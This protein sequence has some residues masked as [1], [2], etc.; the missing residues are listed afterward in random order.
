MS[1]VQGNNTGE[2]ADMYGLP[3]AQVHVAL[4]YYFE[5]L[6]EIREEIRSGERIVEQVK[7]RSQS[8]SQSA[9]QSAPPRLL[10]G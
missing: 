5:N 7:E 8:Q 1:E 10:P 6:E 3:L 9:L 2:I 4:A